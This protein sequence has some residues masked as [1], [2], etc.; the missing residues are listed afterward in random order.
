MREAVRKRLCL[1]AHEQ[2]AP[3][4]QTQPPTHKPR[5]SAS[6]APSTH[7]PGGDA[8][9]T[10]HWLHWLHWIRWKRYFSVPAVRP[11][12]TCRWNDKYTAITG[13]I[14]IVMPANRAGK[15]PL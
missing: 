6:R 5:A 1:S 3:S 15:S 10:R 2:T 12:C 7:R 11:A 4:R 8:V 9:A 13:S 14:A